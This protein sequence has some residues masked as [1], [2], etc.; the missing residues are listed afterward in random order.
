[1]EI[2]RYLETRMDSEFDKMPYNLT[3]KQL[4]KLV[5]KAVKKVGNEV[6]KRFGIANPSM[7]E[8]V[9]VFLYCDYAF[10]NFPNEAYIG[11]LKGDEGEI[12]RIGEVNENGEVVLYN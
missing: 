7:K 5:T 1:M 11:M 3:E 9:N 12:T 10:P 6:A 2:W 8:L 4:D